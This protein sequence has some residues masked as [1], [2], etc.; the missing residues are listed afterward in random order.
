MSVFGAIAAVAMKVH[1]L[2]DGPEGVIPTVVDVQEVIWEVDGPVSMTSILPSG[3]MP[4]E[5]KTWQVVVPPGRDVPSELSPVH[6]LYA[7]SG[8]A[9]TGVALRNV[10]PANVTNPIAKAAANPNRT[11]L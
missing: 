1:V 11:F 3:K 7:G 10:P 5:A 4:A 2:P 9:C 8:W 6:I